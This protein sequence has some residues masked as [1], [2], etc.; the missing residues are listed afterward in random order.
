MKESNGKSRASDTKLLR[1]MD[2]LIQ[3]SPALKSCQDEL[4]QGY[5]M[6]ENCYDHGHKLLIAGNGGS[7]AD[8]EHMSGEL[9]KSFK[10]KRPVKEEVKTAL[11]QIDAV[12]GKYLVRNLETPLPAIPLVAHEAQV[13][14]FMNDVDAAGVFAQQLFGYGAEGD[15]FLGISTS[16]NAENIMYAAVMAK[17]LGIQV[18]G[19]TGEDG[20]KLGKLA[21]VTIR[22]PE[23]ET[24][25]VQELHLPIYHCWC[26]MLEEHFFG[27]TEQ[28]K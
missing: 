9:M 24:Y 7:A 21:D 28:G 20:G 15:V 18:L 14:A 16:G 1:H 25:R 12:R 23:K 26:M 3:R 17:A 4:I 6:L 11:M 5:F 27:S 22:V 8:A 2:V 13:T 10:L 19:L